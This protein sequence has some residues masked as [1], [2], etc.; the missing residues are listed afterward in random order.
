[1][2]VIAVSH[3]VP[4]EHT[5]HG[6]TFK[7]SIIHEPPTSESDYINIDETGVVNNVTAAHDGPVYVLFA[8]NY[9]YWCSNLGIDR[10]SWGWCHWGENIKLRYKGKVRLEDNIHLGDVWR[11]GKSVRLEVCGSRIPCMKVSWRCGQKDD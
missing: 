9:D 10:S 8:Y 11:I 1:M 4:T 6:H 3:S 7:T 2:E 5:V